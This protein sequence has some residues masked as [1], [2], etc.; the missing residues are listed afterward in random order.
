MMDARRIGKEG[1]A[2]AAC[3]LEHRGYQILDRNYHSPYGEIDIIAADSRYIVFVEVKTRREGS[4]VL[5]AQAVTLAKQ[6][7]I[8]LTAMLYLQAFPTEL[9]P[10]FDVVE[11]MTQGGVFR[12]EKVTHLEDAFRLEEKHGIF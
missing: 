5:P 12:K 3:F 1:E 2:F 11:I 7:K 9:Q 6:R 8:L 4:C 10:R